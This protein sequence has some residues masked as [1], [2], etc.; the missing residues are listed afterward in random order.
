MKAEKAYINMTAM[1][2]IGAIVIA[3]VAYLIGRQ[4]GQM[5]A[6]T[7]APQVNVTQQI[8][9]EQQPV[10]QAAPTTQGSPVLTQGEANVLANT[11]WGVCSGG[12]DCRSRTVVITTNTQGQYVVTA[13]YSGIADDSIAAFRYVSIATYANGSW[14]LGQ[15]TKTQ[16]CRM[17]RGHQDFSAAACI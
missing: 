8:P 11:A 17:N 13:T 2:I 14:S 9:A 12:E 15:T 1:V 3:G 4:S 16:Q 10:K 7:P 6:V 5:R